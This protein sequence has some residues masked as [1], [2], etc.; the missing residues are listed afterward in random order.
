VLIALKLT[1]ADTLFFVAAMCLVSAY[2]ATRLNK[3]S[4]VAAADN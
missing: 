2:L 3:A 4:A 1:I